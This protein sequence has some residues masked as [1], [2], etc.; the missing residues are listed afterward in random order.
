LI[1]ENGN[2]NP[3]G[4]KQNRLSAGPGI[5][6]GKQAGK[7]NRLGQENKLLKCAWPG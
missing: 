2:E 3:A 5:L 4:I 1:L 6:A 7:I